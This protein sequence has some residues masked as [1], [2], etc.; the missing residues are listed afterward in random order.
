MNFIVIDKRDFNKIPFS[1]GKKKIN[2]HSKFWAF[3]QKDSIPYNKIKKDDVVYFVKEGTSSWQYA[4]KISK[5]EKNSKF[6]S[7]VWG[8]DLRSKNANLILYFDDK[9]HLDAEGTS[10]YIP[11][12]SSFKPGFYKTTASNQKNSQKLSETLHD[13]SKKKF[14]L[15]KQTARD[16]SKVK[17]LKK[18]YS[19]KCQVCLNQIEIK[20]KKY[21]SEVHHLR[22]LGKDNGEDNL[23]NMIVVCPNHHKEFDYCVI[24]IS[25]DGKNIIDKNNEIIK[26]LFIKKEHILSD[27]NIIY[28]YHRRL[29]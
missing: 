22:P 23:K 19:D 21:Y 12:L 6:I 26:K 16:S 25:L 11:K 5:K 15:I 3:S 10:N 1:I 7:D 18:Y 2:K 27:D 20:P 24:R 28:Q 17:K 14:V 8:N 29:G 9:N 13:V 4:Y